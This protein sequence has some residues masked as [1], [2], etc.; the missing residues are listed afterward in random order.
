MAKILIINLPVHGHVNPTIELTRELILRGHE[1][2]YL[3]TEEFQEE[4]AATGA[5]VI[6]YEKY[7]S[8]RRKSL[9][10]AKC[11]KAAYKKALEIGEEYDLIFYEMIFCLGEKVGEML[12]KPTVELHSVFALNQKNAIEFLSTYGF[13][14]RLAKSKGSRRLL[15]KFF[16][17][18][19]M[20]KG[21][22]MI[23]EMTEN[24]SDLNIIYTSRS[25]QPNNDD[26]DEKKYKFVGPSIIKTKHNNDIPLDKV[27]GKL[28]YISMG[29]IGTPS[30]DLFKKCIQ[31]FIGY[32]ATVIMSVGENIKINN[33]CYGIGTLGA[34]PS[35]IMIY[36]FVPQSDVLQQADLFI[37]H[38]GMDSV[39]EA[40][41]YGAPVI[42]V[43]QKNEQLMTANRIVEL[44]LG[45]KLNNKKVSSKIL[46]KTATS[47]LE[48]PSY[49]E[50]MA[51]MS[52]DMKASG[53][54]E[55]AAIEIEKYIAEIE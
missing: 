11:T 28:I 53:G 54:Y 3:I 19:G 24:T 15:T 8:R 14:L 51:L 55:R 43:P 17:G 1:I 7:I 49:K 4:I 36:P 20:V 38:G 41:Y 29:T 21:D 32:D 44:G 10:V 26:F 39:N 52:I 12:G 48:N 46:R 16:I 37:T 18:K 50:N 13:P 23:A 33:L 9:N 47:I 34:M 35:N 42:V 30:M 45:K 5:T 6:C 40:I 31:A 25:F 2:T 22:D 27:T